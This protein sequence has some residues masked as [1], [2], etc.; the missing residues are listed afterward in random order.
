MHLNVV[1]DLLAQRLPQLIKVVIGDIR[2]HGEIAAEVLFHNFEASDQL[3]KEVSLVILLDLLLDLFSESSQVT[4]G[5]IK[6]I[7]S[8]EEFGL[9]TTSEDGRSAV[10]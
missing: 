1:V 4:L 2:A 8:L 10:K 6:L 3:T 5:T 9:V 7:L